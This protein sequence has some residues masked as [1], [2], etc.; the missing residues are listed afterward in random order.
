MKRYP[1]YRFFLSQPQLYEY[2]KEGAPEIFEQVRER[3]K[4]GRWEADGAMWLE[5]DSNLTSGES[6]I[7]QI[8]YGKKFFNEEFGIKEQEILWLPDAF[9][10]LGALPQIMKK[11]GIRYFLTT[12]MGWN[13]A[14]QQP[15]DTFLWEGIDGSRV[16]GDRKSVV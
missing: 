1:K 11:S 4:E 2:V 16:T 12:K 3:V 14:D 8:L 5:S 9:G 10:F 13:D 7:R 6:L 15:D